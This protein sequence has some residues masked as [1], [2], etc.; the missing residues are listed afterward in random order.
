[1][2]KVLPSLEKLDLK[3][4]ISD[5]GGPNDQHFFACFD[6]LLSAAIDKFNA[7]Q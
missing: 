7:S 5:E 4:L 2:S 3:N 1:M 6:V